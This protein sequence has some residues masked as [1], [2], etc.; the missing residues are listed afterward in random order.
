LPL[1]GYG[2]MEVF[3]IIPVGQTDPERHEYVLVK[4]AGKVIRRV[5]VA[6]VRASPLDRDGAYLLKVE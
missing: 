4:R 2:Y 5:S 1:L 3:G 6:K